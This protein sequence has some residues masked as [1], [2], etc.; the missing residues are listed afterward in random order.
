MLDRTSLVVTAWKRPDYL[1]QSLE[2]WARAPELSELRRIIVALGWSH[3]FD[4]MTG[5]IRAAERQL[6]RAA[7]VVPDSPEASRSPGMHRAL[8]EAID[9][10]FLMDRDADWVLCG[11]EDVIVSADALAYVAW[12]QQQYGEHSLCICLHNRGGAGWD[13]LTAE[14]EDA[15]ADQEAVRELPYFN[16]W[17]WCIRRDKW[18]AVA[19]PVWDWDCDSAGSRDSGYDWQMQRLSSIGPWHNLVP[20][21]ARSQTIGEDFGV[22][23]NPGI[24]PFQQAKS[25][26]RQRDMPVR[27][28]LEGQ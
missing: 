23:S 5:A 8:G 22:Y 11:E 9:T 4:D 28:R 16:P 27:Y 14:R 7:V 21:A 2:S 18:E 10:A 17:G 6:G 24:F 19:R 12:A 1:R 15:D 3:R 25:F 20:D 26:R 13:G